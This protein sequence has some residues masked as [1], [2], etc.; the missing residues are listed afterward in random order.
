VT[1]QSQGEYSLAF[2]SLVQQPDDTIG[3]LAYSLFKAGIRERVRAGQ[4]VPPH[5]RNPTAADIEAYRGSASRILEKYADQVITEAEPEIAARARGTARDEIIE[6]VRG[7]T[8]AWQAIGYGVAAWF[9]SIVITIVV[10]VAAPSWVLRLA[11]QI[12]PAEQV[13][14][15]K[16]P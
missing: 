15:Q 4:E 13:A 11:N 2:E 7:R 8:R 3:L 16:T 1:S 5:L 10:V 6:V 12:N 14:P 9:I